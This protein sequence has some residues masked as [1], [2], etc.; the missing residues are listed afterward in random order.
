MKYKVVGNKTAKDVV[1]DNNQ[2]IGE[3]ET[4][5]EAQIV[6]IDA[7]QSG[8]MAAWAEPMGRK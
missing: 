1:T 8:W 6:A 5:A 2:T 3:Y 7:Q 4:L